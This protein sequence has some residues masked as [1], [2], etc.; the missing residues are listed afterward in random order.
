MD[1]WPQLYWLKDM[2]NKKENNSIHTTDNSKKVETD[3]NF[4]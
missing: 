4:S 1:T 3:E 2:K